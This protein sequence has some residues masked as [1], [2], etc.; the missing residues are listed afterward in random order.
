MKNWNR[1]KAKMMTIPA[2]GVCAALVLSC[3][4]I[5]VLGAIGQSRLASAFKSGEAMPRR[6]LWFGVAGVLLFLLVRQIGAA[7]LLRNSTWLLGVS[8]LAVASG[9]YFPPGYGMHR[10]IRIGDIS[11]QPMAFAA[12]ATIVFAVAHAGCRS[13]WPAVAV[14][15]IIF[16]IFAT[17]S[18]FAALLLGLVLAVLL[19]FIAGD[20]RKWF[21]L[22]GYGG[23]VGSGGLELCVYAVALGALDGFLVSGAG[24]GTLELLAGL[25]HARDPLRRLVERESVCVP[26]Q[27]T[28]VSLPTGVAGDRRCGRAA[29]C[30]ID[31][32]VASDRRGIGGG[33]GQPD[34]NR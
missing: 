23:L 4:A 16:L 31:R 28:R 3:F 34:G 5:F 19:P 26:T 22:A 15:G 8:A 2:Q 21:R 11:L 12:F 30:S 7:R 25:F 10:W 17:A 24:S 27:F 9:W 29:V 14:G 6:H 18:P 32:G 1:L 33:A 20:S 13:R